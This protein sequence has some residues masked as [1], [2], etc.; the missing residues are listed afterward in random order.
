MKIPRLELCWAILG[1][2][3]EQS[4]SQ[5]LHFTQHRCKQKNTLTFKIQM[6]YGEEPRWQ[7][8]MEVFFPSRLHERQPDQH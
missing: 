7:D 1:N 5:F 6:K 2:T 3:L 8:S 4:G